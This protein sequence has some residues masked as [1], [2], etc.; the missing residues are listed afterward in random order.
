MKTVYNEIK[1]Y[2]TKDGSVIRE[3]MHP[4]RDG[5]K[6]QSLAEATIPAGEKTA[7]HKHECSEEIYHILQGKGVMVLGENKITVEIGDTICI[8]PGMRH[9]ILNSGDVDLKILCACSPPYLHDD[10]SL[11]GY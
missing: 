2:T 11:Y 4:D 6:N 7:L 1:T 10:T 9:N 8:P 3:L 5:N